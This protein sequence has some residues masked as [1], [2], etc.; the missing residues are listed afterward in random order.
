MTGVVLELYISNYLRNV[1]VCF[2]IYFLKSC[3]I[4]N[5]TTGRRYEVQWL[6]LILYDYFHVDYKCC[7]MCVLVWVL[8]LGF[9]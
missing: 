3:I 7:L 8:S 4:L 2:Q 6:M 9:L 5:H 1:G